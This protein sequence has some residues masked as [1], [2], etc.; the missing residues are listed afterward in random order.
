M[1]Q[2]RDLLREQAHIG[3]VY[4]GSAV[5]MMKLTCGVSEAVGEGELRLQK[6]T[7]KQGVD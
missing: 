2:R 4:R 6:M 7:I 5:S 3:N 1:V